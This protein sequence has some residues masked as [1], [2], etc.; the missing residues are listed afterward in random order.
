MINVINREIPIVALTATATPKV[1]S[2]IVKNLQMDGVN[3]FIDSFNRTNLYYE[4]R[5]KVSK[6]QA[7]REI[8]QIVKSMSGESGIIYV[9]AR[10]TTEVI[11]ETL[12]LNGVKAAPYHAGLDAKT[13]S[14]IQDE[15]LMEDI[16]VICATIAFGMGIDKPDVRFVIHFD[17]PKSIENYYQET[18]RGGRDGLEGKCYAFYSPKDILKLEKFLRDK[19]VAER[20]MGAQLLEEIVAY[21]ET[22]GCRRKFLLHYFGEYYDESNC[23][24]MCDNCRYPREKIEVKEDMVKALETILLLKENY[25]IKVIVDFL[26]GT[27][28]KEVRQ[29]N[30]DQL[31]G[32]GEGKENGD[33]YWH[34]ILRQAI[35]KDYIRK[36]VE[37]YGVLKMNAS[38]RAFIQ[39][40]ESTLIPINKDFSAEAI[41]SDATDTQK[42]V[43]LDQV[44]VKFLKGLRKQVAK[45][46]NVPPWV[47]FQD[48]SLNDMATQY[49]GTMEALSNISGVSM[50]KAQKYGR[51]FL[52]LINEYVEDNDI[53]RPSDLVV[54]QV[55]N[56]SRSKVAIIQGVD[57]KMALEDI[58]NSNNMSMDELLDEMDMI[59]SS[60]TKLNIRYFLED[61]LDESVM[62]EIEDYL[63]EAETD[64][65]E[66]A[67]EELKEEDI[68][69]EEIK[70][71]RIQFL[72]EVAN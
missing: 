37:Q 60:G 9:Q 31:P 39:K 3:K 13:R 26:T 62:E 29:F 47:I 5:P 55:A 44:L 11:A 50:G 6:T 38:G 71:V 68:T 25:G 72:S 23:T 18:G 21:S 66:E 7:T 15:F 36:E 59:V 64:S 58:A 1:Q 14:R 35:L 20:E 52:D 54:K 65:V 22:S 53:D 34:S 2:D 63:M 40:P 4:V 30:Y 24:D 8:V 45:Q 51:P 12:T 28:S 49:P 17:I 16:D 57:R 19:P 70:L 42:T 56:K 48:P 46:K 33:I 41:E 27:M 67:F 69:M 43:A 61:N 10:K 32:F